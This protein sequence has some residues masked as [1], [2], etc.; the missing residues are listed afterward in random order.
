MST[1]PID[2]AAGPEIGTAAAAEPE[3]IAGSPGCRF[4]SG[5]CW[6]SCWRFPPGFSGATAPPGSS[7]CQR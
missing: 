4:M 1:S 7:S 6:R 5:S 3:G 2:P